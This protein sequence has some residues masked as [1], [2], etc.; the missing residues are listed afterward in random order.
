M[1]LDKYTEE[2]CKG[3]GKVQLSNKQR[4]FDTAVLIATLAIKTSLVLV[5]L[6]AVSIFA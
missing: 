2:K 3:E 5:N 4:S 6:G 1:H